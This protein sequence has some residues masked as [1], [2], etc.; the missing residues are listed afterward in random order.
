[1]VACTVLKGRSSSGHITT[2]QNIRYSQYSTQFRKPEIIWEICGVKLTNE[3]CQ[4]RSEIM[5]AEKSKV[6]EVVGHELSDEELSF[7]VKNT[8]HTVQGVKVSFYNKILEVFSW[9]S[10]LAQRFSERL[11][12]WRS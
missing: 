9:I 2:L 4:D 7:L 10:E 5:G 1:M 12:I 8:D 11:S 3:S 6:K